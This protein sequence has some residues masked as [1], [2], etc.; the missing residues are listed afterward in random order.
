MISILREICYSDLLKGCSEAEDFFDFGADLLLKQER[1]E[2]R[3]VV[4]ELTFDV[5]SN[6]R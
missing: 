1:I 6:V 2:C 3:E 4:F 5:R